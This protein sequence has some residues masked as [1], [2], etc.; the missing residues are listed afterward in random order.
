MCDSIQQIA[1]VFIISLIHKHAC[2]YMHFTSYETKQKNNKKWYHRRKWQLG[3]V[4][5]SLKPG[6]IMKLIK[7]FE[8][9]QIWPRSCV[10][11]N[12][13]KI[14]WLMWNLLTERQNIFGTWMGNITKVWRRWWGVR[15]R[16]EVRWEKGEVSI[17]HFVNINTTVQCTIVGI[18]ICTRGTRSTSLYLQLFN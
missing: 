10:R 7:G 6:I 16:G 13:E 17:W 12:R 9:E 8:S 2:R 1:L 3:K 4:T 15:E 11:V 14:E 5:F 18:I